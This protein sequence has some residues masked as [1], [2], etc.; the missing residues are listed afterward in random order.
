VQQEVVHG[1]LPA[2][3]VTTHLLLAGQALWVIIL[4]VVAFPGIP[5]E[6]ILKLY[7]YS[8]ELQLLEIMF[9]TFAEA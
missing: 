8:K 6:T 7:P 3:P 4:P 5:T 9:F 2:L 1:D